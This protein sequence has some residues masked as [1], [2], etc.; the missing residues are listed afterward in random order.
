MKSLKAAIAGAGFMGA[1]H[2][3]ALRRNGIEVLGILGI[4]V[5]EGRRVAERLALSRVYT[6]FEE[7]CADPGVDV[8]HLCTPNYLHYPMAKAALQAGKHVLCEKPLATTSAEARELVA[9][10]QERKLV[11]AVNYNLRYYPLCQEAHRRVRAGALGEV[12]I[13]HGEYCQ[14]WLFLPTDWNWRLDP[15]LGGALRV[16][17]DIGTHWLDMVTW[18]TGLQVQAVMADFATFYPTRQKPLVEVETF[19][20]KLGQATES[21]VVEIRTEDYAGLLV[22]F[23]GGAHGAFILSQI[24]AGRKNHFVWEING[25]AASMSWDQENPN[26]LW[27]GYR[28]KPNELLLKD[29]A[30]MQPET[31]QFAA[32]PGGHAE[33]YPDTHARLFG[34][35]YKY[36][37]AGDLEAV[38][39][40]PTFEDGW[41]ELALCDAIQQSAAE[42]RWVEVHFE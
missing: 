3:E 7:I 17:A 21:Q 6:T 40:F 41:R 15:E 30:L 26:Q 33:G 20:S 9:L 27:L 23:H 22:R 32:Y 10:A 29:P 38:K 39:T 36:I 1:T 12:R 13:V 28:E 16:V 14:D 8:V 11:G 4:D 18:I 5:A 31:R 37:A 35:V 25:S 2:T 42:G 34:S 24:N 19:A